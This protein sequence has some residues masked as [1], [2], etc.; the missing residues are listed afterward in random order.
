MQGALKL[1]GHTTEPEAWLQEIWHMH[2][3]FDIWY[4][5]FNKKTGASKS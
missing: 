1:K 2:A 3:V 4:K 5:C